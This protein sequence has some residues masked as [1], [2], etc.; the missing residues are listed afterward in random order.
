[1]LLIG[2]ASP[3]QAAPIAPITAAPRAA[4]VKTGSVIIS[5][6]RPNG[7]GGTRDTFIE[8]FNTG[9]K[10]LSLAGWSLR[11]PDEKGAPVSV[12]LAPGAQIGAR[13][14]LLLA[15]R[16]Y[17]LQNLSKADVTYESRIGGG[18]ALLGP[19]GQIIDAVGPGNL[20]AT[21]REG[22]GLP[23]LAFDLA[24]AKAVAKAAVPQFSYVR[25]ALDGQPQDTGDNARDFVLIS[26]NGAFF[27]QKTSI[28]VPGPE[29]AASPRLRPAARLASASDAASPDAPAPGAPVPDAAALA[30]PIAV[31]L[32]SERNSMR[33]ARR[34]T[35][36]LKTYGT[37][38]LRYRLTN[39]GSTPIKNLWFRVSSITCDP[40]SPTA[41]TETGATSAIADIRLIR[42]KAAPAVAPKTAA[43]AGAA[44]AAS[45]AISE[46]E[47]KAGVARA[48]QRTLSVW[49]AK[50]VAV[51]S[52]PLGG[53]LNALLQVEL[54]A[55]GIAPGARGEVTF[56]FGVERTGNYRVV[57]SNQSM[58]LVF[59]GNT[60]DDLAEGGEGGTL[61]SMPSGARNGMHSST[62]ISRGG[63]S[64]GASGGAGA[65]TGPGQS[66]ATDQDA[67]IADG[68]IIEGNTEDG[69]IVPPVKP[70]GNPT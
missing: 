26:V 50:L 23:V 43:T 65:G 69:V 35:G 36:P 30:Q 56:S 22:A 67:G 6:L 11:F 7:P 63:Q 53:G 64:G 3:G 14:H 70:S 68:I 52:Q 4:P 31:Q 51:P 17:S 44:T 5:E 15:G 13:A 60:E 66:A 12:K 40:D 33:R 37:M 27:D 28:G 32:D 16:A 54:P 8:L 1:M 2:A 42:G 41:P 62:S 57:L 61:A 25:R 21:E 59:E 29:N 38:T 20:P 47:V 19:Q 18:V 58:N 9:A 49:K 45:P 34:D 24:L 39:D 48:P 55:G 46:A 10:P